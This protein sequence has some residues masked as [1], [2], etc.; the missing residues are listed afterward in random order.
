L[1]NLRKDHAARSIQK[2]YR[3]HVARLWYADAL[4]KVVLMQSLMRRRLARKQLKQLKIDARSAGHFKDKAYSLEKKVIELTQSLG[5]K[6]VE[7][8]HLSDKM[9]HMENQVKSWKDKFER[10]ESKR[11]DAEARVTEASAGKQKEMEA[12]V[13][14]QN[15]FQQR[16]G[17]MTES[18]R[19]KDEEIENLKQELTKAKIDI[20]KHRDE[21]SA[22]KKQDDSERV[23]AL[24]AENGAL[25]EKMSKM[26]SGKWRSDK[27]LIPSSSNTSLNDMFHPAAIAAVQSMSPPQERHVI[28]GNSP[29]QSKKLRR[30]SS[31]ES[32]KPPLIKSDSVMQDEAMSN[33]NGVAHTQGGD[34][35]RLSLDSATSRNVHLWQKLDSETTRV[36]PIQEEDPIEV[37]F[38][39][40]KCPDE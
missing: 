5:A 14:K 29:I 12:L 31:V 19:S 38:D 23:A 40:R 8:K 18:L 25:K 4:K 6:E 30:H 7:C 21:A 22:S 35:P 34:A 9:N 15:V 32:A 11:T 37:R 27:P 10:S 39:V 24:L 26:I 16:H 3:G 2:V 17:T 33:G 20:H 13:A 1:R 28:P 36:G